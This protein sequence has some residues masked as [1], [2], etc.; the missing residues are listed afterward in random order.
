MPSIRRSSNV[1]N[2]PVGNL[3]ERRTKKNLRDLCD[4]VLWS[5]RVAS[6]HEF[7]SEQERNEARS[8][9]SNMTPVSL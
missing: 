8:F 2:P 5:F 4:E 9:L 1:Q 7:I 3:D 6:G